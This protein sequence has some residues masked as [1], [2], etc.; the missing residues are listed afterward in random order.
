MK[1]EYNKP[2]IK[3]VQVSS[4]LLQNASIYTKGNYGDGSGVTLGSRGGDSFFDDDD[5]DE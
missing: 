4:V 2:Q 1:K 5:W 3:V